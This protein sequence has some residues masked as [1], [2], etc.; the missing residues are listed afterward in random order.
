MRLI[1]YFER[2]FFRSFALVST[3]WISFSHLFGGFT[4]AHFHYISWKLLVVR[5]E[6]LT[7]NSFESSIQQGNPLG[8]MLFA[9]IH[10]RTIHPIT[11]AHPTFVFPSLANDMYIVGPASDVVPI[12]L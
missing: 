5:H 4:H 11:T 1:Q 9:L 6:D 3:P 12:F 2:P 7:I 8:Q 10:L